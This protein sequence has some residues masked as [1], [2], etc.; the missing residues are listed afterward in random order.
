MPQERV[1]PMLQEIFFF[2]KGYYGRCVSIA[3]LSS[4]MSSRK[5]LPEAVHICAE[6]E[7]RSLSCPADGQKIIAQ[8]HELRERERDH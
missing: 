3:L 1:F 7:L 6:I 8:A 4:I 5:D 2:E